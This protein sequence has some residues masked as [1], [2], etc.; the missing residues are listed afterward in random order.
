VDGAYAFRMASALQCLG[1][2]E[3]VKNRLSSSKVPIGIARLAPFSAVLAEAGCQHRCVRVRRTLA[4]S[5]AFLAFG[6][7]GS[8]GEVWQVRARVAEPIHAD[9]LPHACTNSWRATSDQR[10]LFLPETSRETLCRYV[11]RRPVFAARSTE[12]QHPAPL[13]VPLS[14]GSAL[15]SKSPGRQLRDA[16]G[17]LGPSIRLYSIIRAQC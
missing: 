11:L 1:K 17:R 4:I 13:R 6:K 10:Q 15:L 5:L 16:R 12:F 9:G 7:V 14:P 3:I 2:E 8:R